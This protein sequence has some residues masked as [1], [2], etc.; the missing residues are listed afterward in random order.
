[1]GAREAADY[2]REL[3]ERP[4]PYRRRWEQHA[5]RRRGEEI[6]YTAVARVLVEYL[7]QYPER[8]GDADA[9]PRQ[10]RHLV[11]R[12]LS[13]ERLSPSTLRLFIEA[14]LISDGDERQRREVIGKLAVSP[15]ESA[16]MGEQRHL[17]LQLQELHRLGPDG[18][19]AEHR[20]MQTIE[21]V[22]DGLDRYPYRFD[23]AATEVKVLQGGSAGPL[24]EVNQDVSA[25]DIVLA[26]PL[27]KGDIANLEYRTTFSYTE[28]PPPELRRAARYRVENLLIRVQFDPGKLPKSVWWAIWDGREG[29]VIEQE[30][31]ELN[32]ELAVM[33]FLHVIEC[34]VVG[35]H[36]EW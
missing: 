17:T 12:A 33:R 9:L 2:L 10:R 1:M 35:F 36:W 23:T 11:E 6:N 4:G 20:T 28:P 8:P 18:L 24:Y 21:A 27:D 19:P 29:P 25:V 30:P 34:A 7:Q 5:E 3:L 26:Q 32:N 13:G 16:A 15:A 31:V 14:F 22:V